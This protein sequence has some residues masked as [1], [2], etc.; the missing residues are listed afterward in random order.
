MTKVIILAAGEG[1]KYLNKSQNTPKCLFKYDEDNT[2]LD[3]Q[4]KALK[5]NGLSQIAIVGGFEIVKILDKYSHLKFYYNNKWKTTKS[6]YSLNSASQEFNSNVLISYSDVVYSEESIRAISLTNNDIV[7]GYDSTW[8]SRYEGRSSTFLKD[9]EKIYQNENS[10]TVT[11]EHHDGQILG[12][13]VGLVYFSRKITEQLPA[14]LNSLLNSNEESTIG[15][16]INRLNEK[17]NI[18]TIDIEG[19]WAELD[20]P[21]D[22]NHFKFGTKAE[23]L[24]ILQDKVC[25]SSIL[26]QIKFEV[27]EFENNPSRIIEQIQSTFKCDHIVV[28][29][30]AINEDTETSS[31]AGNFHSALNIQ[32]N[33]KEVIQEAINDVIQSYLK[34][35]SEYNASNQVFVQP[36]LTNVSLSGVM[37]TKDL[38]TSAPYY[39]INYETKGETDAITSGQ[40]DGFNTFVYFKDAQN[41]PL[42]PQLQAIIKAAKEIETLTNKTSLD[43]EF[44]IANDRVYILQVRPIAAHKESV[45][46]YDSEFNKELSNIGSF[47]EKK[48]TNVPNT[49]GK[50]SCYGVMPDWNPAEIIGINPRALAFDLY[51]Y[52]I[53][54]EIWGESRHVLGYRNVNYSPG[55]HSFAGKPYVDVRMSFNS[56]TPADISEELT[57]KLID[58]YLDKLE[59]NPSL[60]DK[61]EFDICFTSY[62][63]QFDKSKTELAENGFSPNEINEI[64]SALLRLTN[65]ILTE[66]ITTIESELNKTFSLASKRDEIVKA[67]IPIA[68][69]IS[70]LLYDCKRFGALPFSIL[71][72]YGFVAAIMM[73]SA[74]SKK[75]LSS[76]EYD[77]L[78]HSINTVAKDFVND[79]HLYSN[80]KVS[81]EHLIE[82]YGHLRPGTYDITSKNYKTNFDNYINRES[83]LSNSNKTE[84]SFNL[85][86]S[87][88]QD[89][90][91]EL[92]NSGFLIDAVGLIS[93]VKRATEA[94]ERAKFEFTKNLNLALEYISQLGNSMGFSE[95]K[96]ANINLDKVLK[97]SSNSESANIINEFTDCINYNTQKHLI[98][99]AIRLPELIF[100]VQDIEQFHY[101]VNDPNFITQHAI[102]GPVLYLKDDNNQS[103][104]NHIIFI[105]NADPGFD[106]VFSH[107]IKGLVT[108][109]GGAASHMA[110]RC[111]EF[112]LPAAIGTGTKLFDRFKNAK[113]VYLDCLNKKIY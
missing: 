52:I 30:S 66:K 103:L 72:R 101:P 78:F 98:T 25:H 50:R 73:K 56:F 82:T 79:V 83:N 59:R 32:L 10:I 26:P 99:S 36:Q 88:L 74:V 58:Y 13:F 95:E 15:D 20:A 6:L 91:V 97:L 62:S 87:K 27:N 43:I 16:L 18:T 65:N 104:D 84:Y 105:E 29:S 8:T 54:D 38:E 92:K 39:I 68:D 45:K 35:N 33:N 109:Y 11:K 70:K 23:T 49:F 22:L 76:E 94:R 5:A 81:R 3:F 14:V 67:N 40:G 85:T 34:G 89:L 4:L 102:D 28:R 86:E 60:H 24:N 63:F 64:S 61:V 46:V 9:A 90:N 75:L 42:N 113:H 37:F 19:K 80:N 31:M 7:I 108:K 106:W 51:R 2:I 112:D 77:S 100:S 17:F 93:F 71:A 107:S 1:K 12:E 57:K 48:N 44:A 41:H 96:M 69:K 55:I 47:F 53:T 110:I 21:Q 111:A